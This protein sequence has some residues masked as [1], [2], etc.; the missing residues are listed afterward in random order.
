M[1]T[2]NSIAHHPAADE[3][4]KGRLTIAFSYYHYARLERAEQRRDDDK[5]RDAE[6]CNEVVRGEEKNRPHPD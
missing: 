1:T 2:N 5:R 3:Y 4:L 6:A